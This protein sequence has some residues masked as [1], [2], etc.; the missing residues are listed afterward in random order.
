MSKCLEGAHPSL[1]AGVWCLHVIT[2]SSS[3]LHSC[4]GLADSAETPSR[5]VIAC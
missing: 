5:G 4:G 3:V 1:I 2:E